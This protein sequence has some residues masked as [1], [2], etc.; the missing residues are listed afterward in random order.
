MAKVLV[1]DDSAVDRKMAGSILE[2]RPG[3]TELDK[4]TGITP[5]YAQNGK[6]ALAALSK[7]LP[8]LVLTDLQMPEMNGL[9]FVE[10][11]KNKYPAL[12][13]ILMTAYGSEDIAML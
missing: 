6:E 9:E 3:L 10:E 4:R 8:D 7:E 1:V 5:V 13:V 11:V 2:K 12:P